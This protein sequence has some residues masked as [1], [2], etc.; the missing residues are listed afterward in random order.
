M[1]TPNGWVGC[2][3]AAATSKSVC[4]KTILKEIGAVAQLAFNIA[5][6]VVT[7]GGAT[8]A[9]QAE[10]A[11]KN[12]GKLADLKK[13]FEEM[14]KAVMESKEIKKI[15]EKGKQMKQK[16]DSYG[17]D[18]KKSIDS[19]GAANELIKMETGKV[20]EADMVRISAQIAALVDPTGIASVIQAFAYPKCSDIF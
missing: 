2:G 9:I 18:I 4:V 5:S 7:L 13:K 14:K 3:M 10:N 11:A 1:K 12:A 19:I 15:I 20:T 16:Y 8:A 17:E 6:E